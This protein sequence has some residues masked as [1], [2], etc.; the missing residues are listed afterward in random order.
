MT[1]KYPLFMVGTVF[2]TGLTLTSALTIFS[3]RSLED[4]VKKRGLALAKLFAQAQAP[5]LL[6]GDKSKLQIAVNTLLGDND[7]VD[8]KVVNHRGVIVASKQRDEVGQL[9]AD[10][11]VPLEPPDVAVLPAETLA[12]FE[13]ASKERVFGFVAPMRFTDVPL[14]VLVLTLS[15]RQIED[16]SRRAVEA[17]TYIG[18]G[19]GLFISLLALFILRRELRPLTE[20]QTALNKQAIGEFNAR[21]P[22]DRNDELGELARSFNHM[23]EQTEIFFHYI[24]KSIIDRIVRDPSLA[25]P[26]GEMKELGVV[27]G[28]MRGYTAMSNRRTAAEVVRIINAYFYLFIEI[29]AHFEGV[30]DK[31]MGDALMAVFERRPNEE[32]NRYKHRASLAAAYMKAAT[33]VLNRFIKA[34]L[35]QKEDLGL[36]ACAFGFA[37]AAGKAIVGNMGSRRRMDYT[38]CGRVVN[39]ASRLEKETGRGEVVID[40]FTRMEMQDVLLLE[41]LA[42]VQP[43]GFSAA[44]KVV[45][46]RVYGVADAEL[47]ELRHTLKQIFSHDFFREH[48]LLEGMEGEVADLWIQQAELQI[49]ELIAITPT[50]DLFALDVVPGAIEPV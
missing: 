34:R 1:I 38:V 21:L 36:E 35:D 27:F 28:D 11:N 23:S 43:K 19:T 50:E 41:T 7:V 37:M 9:F 31:T 5:I 40:N 32:D 8:A 45:P 2:L 33:I 20:M 39:L 6:A 29:V 13:Q 46:H 48:V 12:S 22:D 44:E 4:E 24:D 18:V 47:R 16:S 49:M 10:F 26:G 17:S 30:V 14:G 42:T 15:R 25:K 3:Q